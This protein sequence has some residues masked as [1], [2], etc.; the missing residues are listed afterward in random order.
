MESASGAFPPGQQDAAPLGPSEYYTMGLMLV[1]E[2]VLGM[3]LNGVLFVLYVTKKSLRKPSSLLGMS[4]CAGDFGIGLMCPFAAL[5]SF[6]EVWP[7][8]EQGCQL[9]AC[10]GMLFGTVSITSLVSLAV[11]KY[12]SAI[13]NR[14]GQ[15]VYLIATSA[16]WLNAVFWA[17]TPLRFVG[18]GRYGIEPPKTT[19]MLDFGAHGA[20]YVTYL[21]AMMGSVYVLPMGTI[22]WCLVKLREGGDADDAKKTAAKMQAATTCVLVLMSLVVYWGAYGVVALWA[23]A[24][25]ISSVP[26]HLVAAAPLLAKICPIGNAALQALTNQDIRSVQGEESREADKKK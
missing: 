4:L 22:L 3:L 10:V 21:A 17:L 15:K 14:V 12:H 8:G 25:D 26:L 1:V 5:A 6:R 2:G 11:E 9:Y 13:G 18:W 7:Y 20:N 19:C 16:I 23:V 24:D